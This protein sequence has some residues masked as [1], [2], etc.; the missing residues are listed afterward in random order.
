MGKPSRFIRAVTVGNN[1]VFL[2]ALIDCLG[3]RGAR[4]LFEVTPM[5]LCVGALLVGASWIRKRPR[6]VLSRTSF[7]TRGRF[8]WGFE[9]FQLADLDVVSREPLVVRLASDHGW[10]SVLVS[11]SGG[12]SVEG[13]A[14]LSDSSAWARAAA[15]KPWLA[16]GRITAAR[17]I[18]DRRFSILFS[19]L[20]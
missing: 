18:D 4:F 6:A 13:L 12:T 2:Y 11:H 3:G 16:I 9:L 15:K 1:L 8:S 10:L 17:K 14:S 5:V 19:L 7:A 20:A